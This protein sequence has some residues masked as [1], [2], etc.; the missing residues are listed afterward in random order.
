MHNRIEITLT[1]LSILLITCVLAP[2]V[3]RPVAPA[4]S[5]PGAERPASTPVPTREPVRAIGLSHTDYLAHRDKREA[6]GA[7]LRARGVNMVGL[8][9]GRFDWTYFPWPG[10]RERWSNDVR[11]TGADFLA[12]EVALAGDWSYTVAMVDMFVGRYLEERPAAAARS[13]TGQP[14]RLQVSTHELVHGQF[15]QEIL[16]LIEYIAATYPVDAIALT[17]LFYD[18]YGF[19]DDDRADYRAYSG[20]DDWPRTRN[21]AI[22]TG[23]P[24]IGEWRSR[25]LSRFIA[26][27]AAIAH[28]HNKELFVDV[29]VSWGR[30]A[31]EGR[32]SGHDYGRFLAHA[33]RL[34]LWNYFGLSG[35]PPEYGA[36]IA[37]AVAHYGPQ[38]IIISVGLWDNDS[39]SLP[40]EEMLRALRVIEGSA[41][42][43]VWITPSHMLSQKHWDVIAAR[44]G[45]D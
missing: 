7:A 22:D 34:V 10:R 29:R 39:A 14:S 13:A 41:A 33:D 35:Y 36:E 15:G 12:E 38:R 44:W 45:S 27:A 18:S 37:A 6:L 17:E 19:G 40:P 4:G 20:Q 2:D 9:A 31:W 26:R 43:N 8:N 28:R 16:A 21:G 3:A 1:L 32:E 25:A 30:L 23:H 11:T 42:P 5:A 24:L